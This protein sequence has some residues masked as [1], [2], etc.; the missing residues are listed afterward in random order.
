LDGQISPS[1]KGIYLVPGTERELKFTRSGCLVAYIDRG[2]Y[3]L[4]P[5]A[6]GAVMT[7]HK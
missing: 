2:N 6:A 5:P 1:Y 4:T 7:T 3:C